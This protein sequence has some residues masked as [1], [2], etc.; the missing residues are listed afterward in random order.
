MFVWPPPPYVH[1][2][3]EETFE[4]DG[5]TIRVVRELD[6]QMNKP[7]WDVKVSENGER[8]GGYGFDGFAPDTPLR[9]FAEEAA[10]WRR[11]RESRLAAQP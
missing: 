8:H 4:I 11:E 3:L 10:K 2:R 7:Y 9:H 6:G 1:S 5:L